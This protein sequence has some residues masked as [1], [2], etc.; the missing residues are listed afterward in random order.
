MKLILLGPPGAGKG[1]Q[2]AFLCRALDIVQISTGEMLRA[3]VAA[4]SAL[5]ERVQRVLA[6]GDLVDDATIIELVKARIQDDDCANGFLFDGFPRTIPQAQALI[7]AE[8][9][10]DHILEIQVPDEIVVERIAGRRIHEAS[11]RIYHMR[12]DP[13]K[14]QGVDDETGEPL[15]QRPDDREE[16]VRERLRVYRD[17]TAP[18]IG[19]FR[20]L[21]AADSVAYSTVDGTPSA[22]EINARIGRALGL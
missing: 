15:V 12:F 20:D 19:F 10:I 3:A 11:G 21:G 22:L 7:D 5:G 6:S 4:G 2:A 9:E 8:I 14:V 1:T 13:P 16:T 18:L 17:Q